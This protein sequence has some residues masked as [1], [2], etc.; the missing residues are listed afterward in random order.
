MNS[1]NANLHCMS[2]T[3][4][5]PDLEDELMECEEMDMC[6]S[7]DI[8][9]EVPEEDESSVEEGGRYVNDDETN[10][11]DTVDLSKLGLGD[12]I[13]TLQ[14]R[15][16]ERDQ[17]RAELAVALEAI[18]DEPVEQF[19]ELPAGIENDRDLEAELEADLFVMEVEEREASIIR[20]MSGPA[21]FGLGASNQLQFPANMQLLQSPNVWIGDTGASG[22]STGHA[23]GG[24][25]VRAGNSST[26]GMHG[27]PIASS[28]E[29]D[30]PVEHCD[31]SGNAIRQMVITDVSYLKGANFNLCSLTKMMEEGWGMFRDNVDGIVMRPG[32]DE[33][34][35]FD[36]IIKTQKG[37]IYAGYFKRSEEEAAAVAPS[38]VHVNVHRLHQ[39]LGHSGEWS[40]RAT[41]NYLGMD[42]A[43]GAL[44]PCES[45]ALAKARQKNVPKVSAGEKARTQW[46][47]VH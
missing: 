43:R 11:L 37:A 2:E 14:Q 21:E 47:M 4:I 44:E 1:S 16:H 18:G 10:R 20:N 12:L 31:K 45:C 36:I 40:T 6:L 41:G 26:T 8:R 22:H 46:K 24:V 38:Q 17:R 42:I 3:P 9:R 15:E 13:D 27:V 19:L 32:S 35:Y 33:E 5:L 34:V 30:I 7:L 28:K 29:M 23:I 39:M 25:N